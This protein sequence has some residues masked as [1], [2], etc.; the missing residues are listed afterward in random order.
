MISGNENAETETDEKKE[1]LKLLRTGI[2][3]ICTIGN[4]SEKKNYLLIKLRNE[5][6]RM[7]SEHK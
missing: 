7:T 3:S 2:L 1:G 6:R 5:Y 4:K